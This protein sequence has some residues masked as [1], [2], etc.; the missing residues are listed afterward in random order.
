[1]KIE[2]PR[3]LKLEHEE[4]HDTLRK[5]TKEP[6][7]VGEAAKAVARLLHPHFVKEEEFALPSLGLLAPLA[8]GKFA[9]EMEAVLALTDRLKSELP[10]ML[11]EHRSIVQALEKLAHTAREEGREQYAA[12]ADKL[13]L[14]AQAE[15]EVMYPAAL[16]VGELVRARRERQTRGGI[17]LP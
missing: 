13:V 2:I 15:E 3:P 4:L 11:A 14:H 12:F 10:Q 7:P 16:L 6:G 8:Q 5:A 9:P 1:M 17:P